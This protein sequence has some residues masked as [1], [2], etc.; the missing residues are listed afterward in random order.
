MI[1]WRFTLKRV[2]SL[3]ICVISSIFFF[4][5]KV[6]AI[7]LYTDFSFTNEEYIEY[8]NLINSKCSNYNNCLVYMF[9]H[10]YYQNY[11]IEIFHDFSIS[12]LSCYSTGCSFNFNDNLSYDVY[13]F[14]TNLWYKENSNNTI[15]S[16][17]LLMYA[18]NVDT[19]P[20]RSNLSLTNN[21]SSVNSIFTN[22]S[23]YNTAYSSSLGINL[24]GPLNMLDDLLIPKYNYSVN[25]YYNDVLD[26]NRSYTSKVSQ[27]SSIIIE[28]QS[29]DN[30]VIDNNTYNV[31]I[32]E[33]NMIFNIYYY[34]SDYWS[35]DSGNYHTIDATNLS[36]YMPFSMARIKE[37]FPNIDFKSFNTFQQFIVVLLVNIVFILVLWFFA[38]IIRLSFAYLRKWF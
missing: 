30:Y 18:K 9:Y 23:Y 33:D 17:Y 1:L 2:L 15:N 12:S 20:N 10:N 25:Y 37:I 32:N 8:Y 36:F 34:T 7:D 38:H 13:N 24:R 19:I 28:N 27:D 26:S 35:E 3:I 6:K 31:F 16:S 4:N 22:I 14:S 5:S 11:I 29:Y 21:G